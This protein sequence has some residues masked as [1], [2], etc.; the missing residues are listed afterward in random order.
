MKANLRLNKAIVLAI[1]VSFS[2]LTLVAQ[3]GEAATKADKKAPLPDLNGV[4]SND[5][6]GFVNPQLDEKGNV[7]CIVGCPPKPAAEGAPAAPRGPARNPFPKYKPEFAAKVKE[8]S[9]NQ[10]RTDPTLK[11]GNPGLPRIGPPEGIVQQANQVVFLY[12]DLSGSFFRV[13]PLD[14]RGHRAD[15]EETF[16]GDSIGHWE[17]DTLVVE[18]VKFTD[19]FWLSDNGAFHSPQ[20][21]VTE[22]FR[23]VGDKIEYQAI[24]E[25]P[26]VLSEPWHLRPRVLSKS[27]APMNEPTPCVEKDLDHIVDGTHHD[28][29]R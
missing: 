21:K 16:L 17:G 15:A 10:V 13:I 6:M 8:L 4:W 7:K 22:R 1:A 2:T 9:D 29:P 12:E 25:D 20:L 28:N 26:G 19:E 11:C 24:A 5:E 18:A 23:R 27:N 3:I 14:G